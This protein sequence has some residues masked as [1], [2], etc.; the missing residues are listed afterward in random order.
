M[1]FIHQAGWGDETKYNARCGTL[2]PQPKQPATS[3]ITVF[4][5]E[6]VKLR[7]QNFR[8]HEQQVGSCAEGPSVCGL[9]RSTV[10]SLVCLCLFASAV[11]LDEGRAG[12]L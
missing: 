7:L 8:S 11:L 12:C 2:E 9:P 4:D 1:Y 10:T 3:N 6:T 5:S